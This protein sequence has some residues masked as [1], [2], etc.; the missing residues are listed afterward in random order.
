MYF[1]IRNLYYPFFI[2]VFIFYFTFDVVR[3]A[4][5]TSQCLLFQSPSISIN[6]IN[7][8]QSPS[9]PFLHF[10]TGQKSMQRVQLKQLLLFGS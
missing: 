2:L 1:D 8:Y 7:L 4:T 6:P 5:L 10:S 3:S 9:I